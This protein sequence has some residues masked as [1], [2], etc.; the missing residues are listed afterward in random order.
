MSNIQYTIRS[1]PEPVDRFLRNDAKKSGKSL[2]RVI[3][4]ALEKAT[5][6]SQTVQRFN[7]LDHLFGRGIGDRKAFDEAMEWQDSLPVDMDIKL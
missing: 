6:T 7:D 1:I 5:G 3:V 4:E 2:N